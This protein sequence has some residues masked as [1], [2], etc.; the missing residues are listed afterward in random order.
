MAEE[1]QEDEGES[2]TFLA[3]SRGDDGRRE[4]VPEAVEDSK[5]ESSKRQERNYAYCGII[6]LASLFFYELQRPLIAD[7][8]GGSDLEV[9]GP[10][11]TMDNI[12]TGTHSVGGKPFFST[13][14]HGHTF[15]SS[16]SF[17][18]DMYSPSKKLKDWHM[19]TAEQLPSHCPRDKF[20]VPIGEGG[21]NNVILRI[22]HT[23][24]KFNGTRTVLV[25][26]LRNHP[27]RFKPD[28]R[29][30][31][32]LLVP[33]A[34]IYD[35]P[36]FCETLIEMGVCM[37][38]RHSP[39][40]HA[41]AEDEWEKGLDHV[42]R[43]RP[44]F[45]QPRLDM[46]KVKT[47]L[48]SGDVNLEKDHKFYW[49]LRGLKPNAKAAEEVARLRKEIGSSSY[50]AMHMRIEN[51]WRAF[52]RGKYYVNASEI[53]RMTTAQPF[54][55]KLVKQDHGGKLLPVFVA[56]GYKEEAREEWKKVVPH[57]RVIMN[58]PTYDDGLSFNARALVDHEIARE[59]EVFVGTA[60]FSTFT[61]NT[62]FFRG[63]EA[64]CEA[65]IGAKDAGAL[66]AAAVDLRVRSFAYHRVSKWGPT[67]KLLE[68]HQY[69][70]GLDYDE[71]G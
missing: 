67:D 64:L 36:S 15:N 37:L 35:V 69:C 65:A 39:P 23:I 16:F 9:F 61:S 14:H 22:W 68:C 26:Y 28:P 4:N 5:N 29:L 10:G 24:M 58:E 45:F 17:C 6:I 52:K 46:A 40:N 55:R 53:V 49:F 41:T 13:R 70:W 31:P 42:I 51:D 48:A 7:T 8:S 33:F 56:T 60:M 20:V 25:P 27:S 11:K 21:L 50:L 57:V 12:S 1:R 47:I 30:G 62:I 32:S 54:F 2:L 63:H 59:A 19:Q 3:A 18:N 43:D 66:A 44:P 71:S 38:C 34:T